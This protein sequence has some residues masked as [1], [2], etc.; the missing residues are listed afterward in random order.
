ME[1]NEKQKSVGKVKLRNLDPEVVGLIHGAV[2]SGQIAF[3][4]LTQDMQ[5]MLTRILNTGSSGTGYNDAELRNLISQLDYNKAD[6]SAL[7]PLFNKSVDKITKEM[8]EADL[9]TKLS[10]AATTQDLAAFRPNTKRIEF[11]DLTDDLQQKMAD[12]MKIAESGISSGKTAP[13]D[14]KQLAAI[15]QKV[16]EQGVSITSNAQDIKVLQDQIKSVGDV[17]GLAELTKKND[18][19]EKNIKNVSDKLADL[20]GENT[21]GNTEIGKFGYDHLKQTVIDNISKGVDALVRVNAVEKRVT[22]NEGNITSV[23]NRVDALAKDIADAQ[24]TAADNKTAADQ[25]VSKIQASVDALDSKYNDLSIDVLVKKNNTKPDK[26]KVQR[27]HIAQ[28]ILDEIDKVNGLDKKIDTVYNAAVAKSDIIGESGKFIYKNDA[29]ATTKDIINFIRIIEDGDQIMSYADHT[30][31]IL[32]T[33]SNSIYVW[34][35][36][37]QQDKDKDAPAGQWTMIEQGMKNVVYNYTFLFDVET[38]RLYYNNNA[39][40]QEISLGQTKSMD[41]TIQK[42]T[43]ATVNIKDA[44]ERVIN[45]LVLDEEDNST[46][47]GYYINCEALASMAY[48][49]LDMRIYNESDDEHTF[50]VIYK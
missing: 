28:D 4:D 38:N 7:K 40:L 23:N 44:A 26:G 22:T 25:S 3:K 30:Y 33:G 21:P 46:T 16:N 24:K 20:L 29:I 5:S 35:A 27:E 36:N 34:E 11:G 42:N 50:R 1:L 31:P 6:K 10:N 45:V 8:L 14:D 18:T 9:G 17:S 39:Q 12:V 47:K 32:N 37:S 2:Q 49:N 43:Y 19:N 15:A 13:A 48:G 41:V